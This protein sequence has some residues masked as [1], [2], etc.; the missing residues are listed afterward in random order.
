MNQTQEPQWPDIGVITLATDS[1]SSRWMVRHHIMA[2]LGRY[3]RVVWVNPAHSWREIPQA[4]KSRSRSVAS[5]IS[6]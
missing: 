1:W 2:R 6:R 4:W 5:R 3:F